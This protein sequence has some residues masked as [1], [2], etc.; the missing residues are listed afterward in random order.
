MKTLELT[1]F[2]PDEIDMADACGKEGVISM[3]TMKVTR[4]LS[5]CSLTIN[6]SSVIYV[7]DF[8]SPER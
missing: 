1:Q 8:W 4:I 5:F 6:C 7:F 3:K 2:G